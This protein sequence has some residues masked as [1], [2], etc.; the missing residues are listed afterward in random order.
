VKNIVVCCDG[1]R[2]KYGSGDENTNVVRLFERLGKDGERQISFYD[3]G[4]GTYSPQQNPLVRGWKKAKMAITGKGVM[5]NVQEAYRY[6][7]DCYEPGDRVYLFGYS[8]G[9]YTVRVLVAMLHKCGL[10]TKGSSN[11]IPYAMEIYRKRDDKRVAGFKGS[12]SRECKPHFIG[13]WDTVAST[14]WLWREKFSNMRLNGDVKHAYHAVA[15]DEK[16]SHFPIAYW[17]E[18]DVPEGQTLEQVWFAG[19][20]A[21]VGG[22][23]KTDRR[24][25]DI[26]LEWMLRHA[27][28]E[29]LVLRDG[30]RESLRPDPLGEIKPSHRGFWWLLP[31]KERPIPDGAKVHVS[32]LLRMADSG[33]P[34][35][36]TN[37]PMSYA[38]TG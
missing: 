7:M 16:R 5:V 38:E 4:V 15:V 9:A 6:L 23:Q 26:S 21:D 24:I 10:L 25:P 36:P 20:H 37:L 3:P 17:D 30:W 32:V 11:L 8:R 1:T 14:G 27:Q 35:R 22:Q 13:V 34:Y 33:V 2:A 19:Y 18:S 28:N 29:E 31:K 12:F